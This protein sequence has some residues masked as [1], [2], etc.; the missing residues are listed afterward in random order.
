MASK[1]ISIWFLT[2]TTESRAEIARISAQ[3]IV[4]GQAFSNSLLIWSMTSKPLAELLLGFDPFSLTMVELLSRSKD[5]SHPYHAIKISLIN[6]Y[7]LLLI[8]IRS[9][10][11]RKI[12]MT[13]TKISWKWSLSKD[14]TIQAYFITAFSTTNWTISLAMGHEWS[15]KYISKLLE[16]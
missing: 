10:C 3:D 9:M 15:Q 14:A 8:A 16:G 7:I 2:R 1:E 4:L 12:M 13:W 6:T 11:I 5:A